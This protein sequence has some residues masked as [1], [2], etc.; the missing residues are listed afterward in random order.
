MKRVDYV[1]DAMAVAKYLYETKYGGKVTA[2]LI[3]KILGV[4]NPYR[5][6]AVREVLV[7]AGVIDKDK[8][9]NWSKL[10]EFLE[11]RGVQVG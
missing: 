4:S 5:I 3:G 11:V 7:S 2:G 9:V 1:S 6:L 10:A 8:R